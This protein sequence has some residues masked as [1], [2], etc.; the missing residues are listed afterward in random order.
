MSLLRRL[1]LCVCLL[2]MSLVCPAMAQTGQPART[3]PIEASLVGEFALQS[4]QLTDAARSYLDAARAAE[5]PVLAE[6]ATRIALLAEQDAL[7]E[8]G[9][10]LWRTLQPVP[11]QAQRA[12]AASLA[13]RAGKTSAARRELRILLAQPQGWQ[14][15]LFA[16][17]SAAGRQPE[18]V[19]TLTDEIIRRG[20]LPTQLQAWLAFGGLAQRLEQPKLLDRIVLQIMQ[21]FPGEPQVA[22]L[23]AQWLREAGRDTQAREVLAPL[24]QAARQSTQL[25]WALAAEYEALGDLAQAEQILADGAQ[26][27]SSYAQRAI[28]LDRLGDTQRLQALYEE[29]RRG[30]TEPSASR[31]LLLGQLAELLQRYD[32]ALAWYDTLAG[33][34]APGVARLRA[35]NVRHAMGQPAQAYAQLRDLQNDAGLDEETRRDAY[36]LEAE[37]RRKDGDDAGERD[38]YAR[39]LAALPDTLELLYARALMWER[40]D[41]IAQAEA[42]LRRIL[43]IEPDNVAAL[44]ALGYTLADRTTRYREALALIDRARVAAPDNPAIIDSYGWVLFR[45]GRLREALEQLRRAYMLQKDADIASHLAQVLWAMGRRDEARRYFEEARRIDP[46]N[47]TLQRAQREAGA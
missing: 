40:Q 43:V 16:L 18:R 26:D 14:A 36:L 22:L 3:D 2:A 10:A 13:L 31:R 44:N 32:E 45:L 41:Q 20:W 24:R 6:R 1:G 47:R 42:D 46:A 30:A 5:D 21:R 34:Q 37:L 17:T 7:A 39:G 27:D 29:V 23:R 15:A 33:L 4:G 9:L 12:L 38:A 25:R 19:A 35:A 28:L 11:S 8:Q